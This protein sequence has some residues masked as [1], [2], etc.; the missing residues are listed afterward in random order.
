MNLRGIPWPSAKRFRLSYDVSYCP[1]WRPLMVF[2]F[3]MAHSHLFKW[4]SP[5]LL[6]SPLTSNQPFLCDNLMS[7][8]RLFQGSF[9]QINHDVIYFSYFWESRAGIARYSDSLRAGRSGDR[10]PVGDKIFRARPDR[11]RGPPSLLYNRYWVFLGSKAAGSW[12]WPPTPT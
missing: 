1:S 2:A 11:P 6:H 12:R 10:I 5:R 8:P 7:Y 9:V 4:P 3:C